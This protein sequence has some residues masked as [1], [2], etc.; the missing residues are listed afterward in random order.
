[1]RIGIDAKWYFTGPPSGR[2]VVRNIVNHIIDDKNH[3]FV[4]IFDKKNIK[5]VEDL[6]LKWKEKKN[7]EYKLVCNYLNIITNSFL[8]PI[9]LNKLN[10][11]ALMC[12]NY[13]PLWGLQRV[14]KIAYIHDFL[15]VDYPQYFSKLE[16][17]IY[18]LMRVS[19]KKSD[20]VIT[21]S[22]SERERIKKTC[23][24]S[25]EKIIFVHHGIDP[26]FC[27][28]SEVEIQEIKRRFNLP[29][30]FVLYV[31]RLNQRKNIGTLVKS[32]AKTVTDAKLVI[33]GKEEH[34]AYNLK[35]EVEQLNITHRV[36]KLGFLSD[37]DLSDILAAATIFIFP[38]YAEGFGLPP[39]EAMRSGVPVIVSDQT[40]LPEVCGDAAE[41]FSVNSVDDLASKINILLGNSV[42][43]QGLKD[44]S[45]IHSKRFNWN[46]SVKGLIS[47]IE[48]AVTRKKSV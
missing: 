40:S 45:L 15:F 44:K 2:N 7:I 17:V 14:S 11:D 24:L 12:Q 48:V 20:F 41:Y 46:N 29:N 37:E 28:R 21:I 31:G 38:S 4:L 47:G 16:L 3:Q 23:N 25:D 9:Y 34:K 26:N 18:Q 6:K 19:A 36:I 33:I 10:L 27:P 1:M 22:N 32:F 13:I 39:L 5:G 30:E 42:I 8:F 35:R 43:R